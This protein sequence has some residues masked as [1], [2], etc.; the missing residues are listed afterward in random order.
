MS[1]AAVIIHKQ[2][3]YIDQF[4]QH[5]AVNPEHS[6]LPESIGVPSN[7]IFSR[8]CD[9]GVFIPLGDGT[10]Y[11]DVRT[12]A[13]FRAS[14]RKGAMMALFLVLILVLFYYFTGIR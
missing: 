1:G 11:L 4:I 8:L 5:G 14:R 12:L 9:R 13:F 2:N 6:V 7:Y 10:Y 3:K